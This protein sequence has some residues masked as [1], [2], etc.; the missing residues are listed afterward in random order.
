MEYNNIYQVLGR[1][2]VVP[3]FIIIGIILVWLC[4]KIIKKI[5]INSEKN[6]IGKE[7]YFLKNRINV[8]LFFLFV[9]IF[10]AVINHFLNLAILNIILILLN[11]I[12]SYFSLYLIYK[13]HVLLKVSTGSKYPISPAEAVFLH[14][15]PIYNIYWYVRW[16]YVLI[17]ELQKYF[18]ISN[19]VAYTIGVAFLLS[20]FL[21]FFVLGFGLVVHYL[22]LYFL[23]IK[24]VEY[25]LK[26]EKEIDKHADLV[27]K[28]EI[29]SVSNRKKGIWLIFAPY[30]CLIFVLVIYACAT[31]LLSTI[32][33]SST[34]GA[35]VVSNL[36]NV[37]LG[38]LGVATLVF[39]M[40]CLPLGAIYLNKKEWVQVSQYDIRSGEGV[41]SVLPI[42][43]M[44]W[45][46]GAALLGPIWGIYHRVWSS[47]L[48]F[49]PYINI[50]WWIVMG[51]KGN[52]WAWRKNKWTSLEVFLQ[53]QKVWNKWAIG[54]VVFNILLA[55]VFIVGIVFLAINRNN[56]NPNYV[57]DSS[58][59]I[60]EFYNSQE[61]HVADSV[62]MNSAV[63][64]SVA[65]ESILKDKLE[66]IKKD[67]G[68]Y[69]IVEAISFALGNDYE[70][71]NIS[72]EKSLNSV[73]N[74]TNYRML[75]GVIREQQRRGNLDW[76]L[77]SYAISYLEK[78]TD[79]HYDDILGYIDII[80]I[81]IRDTREFD[82]ALKYAEVIK[83][84]DISHLDDAGKADYYWSLCRSYME[85]KLFDTAIEYCKTETILYPS[86]RA[87]NNFGIIIDA[88]NDL[89]GA[90]EN[91]K[92]ALQLNPNSELYRQ[93][94]DRAMDKI[95]SAKSQE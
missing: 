12:L 53:R 25:S 54:A 93:N 51:V 39:G 19:F 79:Q 6:E 28:C 27:G 29:V 35:S 5:D 20:F 13:I 68:N 3:S 71:M 70:Q 84:M 14:F 63:K 50:V 88:K 52:E 49:V 91:F 80:R 2:L 64:N 62:L 43:I 18:K 86:D 16:P 41:D 22:I 55:T 69:Y 90:A 8:S 34:E 95:R 94:Y 87:F 47:L 31:F 32:N 59:R 72:F 83:D 78:H 7:R 85:N 42:E 46:W 74:P 1:S 23:Y 57:S 30:V 67:D 21:N 65:V 44:K 56:K 76:D 17:R 61:W 38:I 10:F 15:I 81:L 60:V 40:V 58:Y 37:I 89:E 66:S 33:I 26:E 92:K 9:L 11:L 4:K 82:K 24:V 75:A 77:S 45:S 36:I 48:L 73:K